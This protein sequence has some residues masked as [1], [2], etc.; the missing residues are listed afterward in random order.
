M[1][2]TGA[3]VALFR[4]GNWLFTASL[5]AFAKM[6][7]KS[8]APRSVSS[9]ATDSS[10]PECAIILRLRQDSQA[11]L[12]LHFRLLCFLLSQDVSAKKHYRP[13]HPQISQQSMRGDRQR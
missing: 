2:N 12:E 4:Y 8:I 6:R 9:V 3:G 11:A 13:L 10:S 1:S 7:I 5:S